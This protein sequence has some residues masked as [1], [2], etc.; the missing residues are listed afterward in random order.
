MSHQVAEYTASGMDGFVAK[1]IEISRLFAAIEAAV[2][3][4]PDSSG[5]SAAG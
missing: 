1:P 4:Q 3:E 5:V 2:S